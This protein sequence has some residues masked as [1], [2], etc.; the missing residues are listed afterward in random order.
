MNEV[1]IL[2]ATSFL[3]SPGAFVP[4][5]I[6]SKFE[7]ICGVVFLLNHSKCY[8]SLVLADLNLQSCLQRIFPFAFRSIDRFKVWIVGTIFFVLGFRSAR[9]GPKKIINVF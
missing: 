1:S 9:S 6:W 5:P 3:S 2:F 7:F 4:R 8:E